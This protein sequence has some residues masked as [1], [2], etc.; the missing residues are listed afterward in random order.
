MNVAMVCQT[1][2]EPPVDGKITRDNIKCKISYTAEGMTLF[3]EYISVFVEFCDNYLNTSLYTRNIH[4]I[5]NQC[6]Q[7]FY[8]ISKMYVQS[9]VYP[10]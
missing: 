2:I 4:K 1:I 3:P 7:V 8:K 9:N 6:D 5:N 10:S